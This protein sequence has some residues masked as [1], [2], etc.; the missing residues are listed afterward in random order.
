MSTIKSILYMTMSL[1]RILRYALIAV[2]ILYIIYIST[3]YIAP[4]GV[5]FGETVK[6][7]WDYAVGWLIEENGV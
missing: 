7:F 5:T 2:L 6:G 3:T 4:Q 1:R